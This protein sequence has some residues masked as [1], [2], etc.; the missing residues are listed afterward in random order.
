MAC[1]LGAGGFDQRLADAGQECGDGHGSSVGWP[2]P[3]IHAHEE[4]TVGK[5]GTKQQDFEIF[6][7]AMLR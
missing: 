6:V 7:A 2:R 3:A 1:G 5:I 4:L